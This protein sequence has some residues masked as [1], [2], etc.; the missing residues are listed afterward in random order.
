MGSE[1][2]PDHFLPNSGEDPRVDFREW[3]AGWTHFVKRKSKIATKNIA[4]RRIT[5]PDPTAAQLSSL[6]AL[7]YSEEDKIDDLFS[8][9]GTEGYRRFRMKAGWDSSNIGA[10]TYQEALSTCD[11]LFRQKIRPIVARRN[12]LRRQQKKT[13][14]MEEFLCALRSIAKDCCFVMPE[15]GAVEDERIAEVAVANLRD[16]ELMREI[17]KEENIPTLEKL[18]DLA[19][20]YE[21]RKKTLAQ[22][23]SD[24]RPAVAGVAEERGGRLFRTFRRAVRPRLLK[25]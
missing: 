15:V 22:L 5:L 20:K 14:S 24:Y 2:P 16:D 25:C 21:T 3:S 17:L 8:A 6:A 23:K 10:H 12:L 9:L 13:E 11:E 7:D 19:D 18:R 4:T 1:H